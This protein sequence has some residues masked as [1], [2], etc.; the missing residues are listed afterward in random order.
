MIDLSFNQIEL[1]KENSLY[2]LI[3]LNNLILSFNKISVI[4]ENSF[5]YLPQSKA[6]ATKLF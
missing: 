2:G 6:I 5:K 1:I 3:K 4:E